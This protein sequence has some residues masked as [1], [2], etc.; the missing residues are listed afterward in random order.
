MAWNTPYMSAMEMKLTERKLWYVA[1]M[2]DS[3]AVLIKRERG[4]GGLRERGNEGGQCCL[5]NVLSGYAISPWI[6][7][8]ITCPLSGEPESQ[9]V[10]LTDRQEMA[11]NSKKLEV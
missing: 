1:F 2:L 11:D 4:E 10:R 7:L 3:I 8:S 5:A 9:I 6:A